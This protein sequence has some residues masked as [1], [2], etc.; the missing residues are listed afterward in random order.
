MAELLAGER[1][2]FGT[3]D[4]LWTSSVCPVCPA[5]GQSNGASRYVPCTDTSGYCGGRLARL[6]GLEPV[7]RVHLPT[8]SFA[9]RTLNSMPV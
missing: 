2:E 9:I 3:N 4:D 7:H 8:I 5:V 1:L 6:I